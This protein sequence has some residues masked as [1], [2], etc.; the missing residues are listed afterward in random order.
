MTP[1]LP[2]PGCHP[3]LHLA[4]GSTLPT[5]AGSQQPTLAQDPQRA[6]VPLQSLPSPEQETPP[7]ARWLWRL[8]RP[9]RCQQVRE[10]LWVACRLPPPGPRARE[11]AGL[12]MSAGGEAMRIGTRGTHLPLAGPAPVAPARSPKTRL[13]RSL[14]AARGSAS[15]ARREG[16][17]PVREPAGSA[18][19][20]AHTPNPQPRP[21]AGI[22]AAAGSHGAPGPLPKRAPR[23]ARAPRRQERDPGARLTVL[24]LGSRLGTCAPHPGTARSSTPPAPAG[25]AEPWCAGSAHVR[26]D[27]AAPRSPVTE[28]P[29]YLCALE[30]PCSSDLLP[31][32]SPKGP[33]G[34][35]GPPA[36]P[37]PFCLRPR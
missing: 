29:L 28:A 13:L 1:G 37:F 15:Q 12:G 18:P 34:A 3:A 8:R 32:S 22:L 6:A 26:G 21:R 25:R 35:S 19:P 16:A 11:R 4:A 10:V 33:P 9:R 27:H 31:G 24:V 5:P 14:G 2:R 36:A 20:H 23:S 30:T 17:A 7:K